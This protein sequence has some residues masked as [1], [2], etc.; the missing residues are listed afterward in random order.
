MNG[1]EALF[2]ESLRRK[3]CAMHNGNKNKVKFSWQKGK[4]EG[5]NQYSSTPHT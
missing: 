4:E 3:T 1:E 2:G 5:K